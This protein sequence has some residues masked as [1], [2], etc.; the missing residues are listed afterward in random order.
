M[1]ESADSLVRGMGRVLAGRDL[2]G[3]KRTDATFWRAGTRVLPKVEGKVRRRSEVL[4]VTD[5]S[6]FGYVIAQNLLVEGTSDYTHL[7]LIS[8]FLKEASRTHL[9]DRWRIRILPGVIVNMRG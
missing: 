3:V 4:S 2:D 7:T 9:D 5:D 8:D 1:E 6:L